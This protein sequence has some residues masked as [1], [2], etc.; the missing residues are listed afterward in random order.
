MQYII[1]C[2]ASNFDVM[3]NDL[4]R[5]LRYKQI[6][7]LKISLENA[8]NFELL[9]LKYELQLHG[10]KNEFKRCNEIKSAMKPIEEKV[11]AHFNELLRL[12]NEFNAEFKT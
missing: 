1:A 7:E 9:P 6:M 12:R 4:S 11:A 10:N 2:S 5:E 8:I 3:E